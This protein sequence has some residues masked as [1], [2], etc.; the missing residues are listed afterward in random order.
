M[1]VLSPRDPD[2]AR[3]VAASFERQ[4]FMRHIGAELVAVTPG[5]CEIALPYRP[6][7]CQQHGFFHGGVV[8][9]L[10]DNVCGYAA[11]SLAGAE[12]SILT[13]EFK[14]NILSPGQ[15]ERLLARGQVVKA[16]RTLTISEARVYS[17][18]EGQETLCA[19]ALETLMPLADRADEPATGTKSALAA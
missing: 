8:S 2:F 1:P 9:T 13:V 15:G 11:F 16:G 18:V 5:A 19:V 4:A 14:V 10:A 7:L 17:V 12:D 3:R 6:E